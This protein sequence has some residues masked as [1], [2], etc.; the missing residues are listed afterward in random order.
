MSRFGS[1]NAEQLAFFQT[2]GIKFLEGG[3]FGALH[4]DIQLMLASKLE[5][6]AA[7]IPMCAA[8]RAAAFLPGS[9]FVPYTPALQNRFF[10]QLPMMGRGGF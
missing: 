2:S 6:A 3:G 10:L 1:V 5:I 8:C 7:S 4:P 9:G